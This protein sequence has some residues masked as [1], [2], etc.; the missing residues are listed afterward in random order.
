MDANASR[1]SIRLVIKLNFI[2]KQHL[3]VG[4]DEHAK[5]IA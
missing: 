2:V 4:L 5:L 1:F 3:L